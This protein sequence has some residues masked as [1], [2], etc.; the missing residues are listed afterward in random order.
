MPPTF[1]GMDENTINPSSLPPRRELFTQPSARAVWAA[2]CALDIALQWEVLREL[3]TRLAAPDLLPDARIARAVLALKEAAD[4]LGGSPL[5]SEYEELRTND[6]RQAGWPSAHTV[7][8]VLAG[9]WNECLGRAALEAVANGDVIVRELGSSFT[10]D[11]AKEA[12]QECRAD[13]GRIP[14]LTE[15]I[16]WASKQEVKRRPGRRPSSQGP[17]DRLF[18]GYL[19]ALEAAGL[20][21]IGGGVWNG[22]RS[23]ATR[24]GVYRQTDESMKEA[25]REVARR[26]RRSPTTSEYMLQREIVR[27]ESEDAGRLRTLPSYNAIHRRFGSWEGALAAAGLEPA[28][29]RQ[30]RTE[31]PEL[32]GRPSLRRIP[33]EVIRAAIC[34][35]YAE[36]GDPFTASAYKQW[37]KQKVEEDNGVARLVGR[38]PAYHTI[39]TRYRTWEAAVADALTPDDGDDDGVGAD[40]AA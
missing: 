15:Y 3:Q 31:R 6:Y 18:G 10:A 4:A 20:C 33:D 32:K 7:R 19:Q 30:R 24:A 38:Y 25:L 28:N 26:I 16:G 13:L 35:A 2:I 8:R 12:L 1:G 29:G 23:T 27:K 17:F 21:D 11:E 5:E 14:T 37:Q 40:V 39:W 36:L 34:E 9:T 22:P